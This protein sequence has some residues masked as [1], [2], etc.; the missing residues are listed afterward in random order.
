[1][2]NTDTLVE[3]DLSLERG[4]N[5]GAPSGNLHWDIRPRTVNADA[6]NKAWSTLKILS[7]LVTAGE[8]LAIVLHNNGTYYFGWGADANLPSPSA[9]GISNH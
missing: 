5:F 3:L 7:L 4:V 2:Q 1:V 9:G 6:T 8:S